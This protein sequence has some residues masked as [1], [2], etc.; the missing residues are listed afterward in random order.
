MLKPT[1]RKFWDDVVV[2]WQPRGSCVALCLRCVSEMHFN[3][4]QIK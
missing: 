4:D 2:T 3:K 1:V